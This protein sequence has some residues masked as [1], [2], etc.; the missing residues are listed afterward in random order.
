MDK[1][2]RAA[3][4]AGTA[5]SALFAQVERV[6]YGQR[7]VL[8]L[9]FAAVLAEGH[10]LVED[11]P[12][13]GKTTLLRVFSRVLGLSFARVSF[14]PDLL[15]ADLTGYVYLSP[16]GETEFRRGPIFAHVLL[17]DELNR[18]SPRT[19]AALLEAMEERRVTV[20]GRTYPLPRPFFVLATQNPVELEGTY[21][22]P[23]A[24]LDRFLLRLSLGYPPAAAERALLTREPLSPEDLPEMLDA[25]ALSA[26][27]ARARAV[28]LSEAVADYVVALARKTR[29]HPRVLLGVSPRG[30]LGLARLARAWA[31]L[32]GR[33]YVLPEDVQRLLPYAWGH[34]ILLADEENS[35]EAVRDLLAEVVRSTPL[36]E[37]RRR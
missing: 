18:A 13:V 35:A 6:Y 25:E 8:E 23:E 26:H 33:E 4:G 1:P 9:L 34:R 15:P 19:Q 21:P 24:E 3:E 31:Y 32:R 17:A 10:V 22:L 20:E 7:E 14:T 16:R 36:P 30:S 29:T 2:E 5:F 37:E 12:G 28:Y 27:I 11:V